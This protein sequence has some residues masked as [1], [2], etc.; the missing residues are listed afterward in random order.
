MLSTCLQ[1]LHSARYDVLLSLSHTAFVLL[2]DPLLLLFTSP[3]SSS[4]LLALPLLVSLVYFSLDS[5]DLLL[6]DPHPSQPPTVFFLVHHLICWVGLALPLITGLDRGLILVGL[7][8]GEVANPPR[9]CAQ[10]VAAHGGLEVEAGRVGELKGI[11][12]L[13]REQLGWYHVYSLWSG[14]HLVVFSGTR[15]AGVWYIWEVLWPRAESMWTLVT[16]VAIA[17]FSLATVAVYAFTADGVQLAT[18]STAR[19]LPPP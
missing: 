2:V 15:V 13:S 17:I 1:L 19:K 11:D 3:F 7:V 12:A 9:L 5:L 10:M 18:T 6:Y 14:L 8:L 4:P 16:A